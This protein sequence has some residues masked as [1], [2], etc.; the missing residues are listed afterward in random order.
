MYAPES[1]CTLGNL[2]SAAFKEEDIA[3]VIPPNSMCVV[4][5]CDL[6]PAL[7]VEDAEEQI[8]ILLEEGVEL[9]R[10]LRNSNRHTRSILHQ[11]RR[12]AALKWRSSTLCSVCAETLNTHVPCLRDPSMV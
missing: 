4:H 1:P 3:L 7:W 12:N 9:S 11:V 10:G 6:Q 2:V 8:V 5:V